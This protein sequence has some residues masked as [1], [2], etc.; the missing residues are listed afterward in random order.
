MEPILYYATQE[1][2]E[3]FLDT[4]DDS[5]REA[6]KKR[7]N[8]RLFQRKTIRDGIRKDTLRYMRDP[9]S[10]EFIVKM[11][12]FGFGATI[13]KMPILRDT[14]MTYIQDNFSAENEVVFK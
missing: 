10:G 11:W 9:E 8:E 12:P 6:W 7:Y 1:Q 13:G 3:A 4:F 14:M 2:I 5:V